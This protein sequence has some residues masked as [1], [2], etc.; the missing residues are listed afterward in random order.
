MKPENALSASMAFPT[1]RPAEG[2]SPAPDGHSSSHLVAGELTPPSYGLCQSS[3]DLLH[4][5]PKNKKGG[6]G[7]CT[8]LGGGKKGRGRGG[9]PVQPA[10]AK[11]IHELEAWEA[12]E[13]GL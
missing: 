11:S 7:G 12:G 3:S 9:G 4:S 10:K 5:I 6:S 8:Q 1:P 13:A 2:S